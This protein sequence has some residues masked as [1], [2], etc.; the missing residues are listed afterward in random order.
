M[1]LHT[2]LLECHIHA[3]RVMCGYTLQGFTS[4]E[5]RCYVCVCVCVCVCFAVCL[6]E[7][8]Y[9]V[10]LCPLSTSECDPTL[11]AAPP[12]QRWEGQ[13]STNTAEGGG[14]GRW[15]PAGRNPLLLITERERGL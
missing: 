6:C 4:P 12:G 13:A 9:S 3:E 10:A 11:Q 1:A 7:D 14:T 2:V 15:S 8:P 5:K